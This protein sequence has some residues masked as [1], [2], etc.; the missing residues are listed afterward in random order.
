MCVHIITVEMLVQVRSDWYVY[1][2]VSALPW[3]GR[4]LQERKKHELERLLTAI[5][6]YMKYVLLQCLEAYYYS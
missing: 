1:C 3:V 5:D 2:V 4:E 6:N